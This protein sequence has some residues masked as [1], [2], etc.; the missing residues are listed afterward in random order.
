MTTS[1]N[2]PPIVIAEIAQA[3]DGS[4][5]LAHSMVD[6]V[7]DSGTKHIKFQM[8]FADQ[9]STQYDRFRKQGF[10]Q[11]SSRYD[12]WKR[13]EFTDQ[14]WFEIF[15]HCSDRDL[16]IVVSPF[17]N[18]ALDLCSSLGVKTIKVGSGETL[19]LP[20]LSYMRD[21]F[22]SFIVSTG[23]STWSETD[24]AYSVLNSGNN[25]VS[26][27]QCTS[28]YPCAL[29][30]VGINNIEL[31]KKR[32]GC[33]SG[34]SDHSGK[35]SPAL[36]A[37]AKGYTDIIELHVTYSRS[38]FGPD[39]TSSIDFGELRLLND[40]L[41]D[42]HVMLNHP[43]QKHDISQTHQTLRELFGRSLYFS[44]DLPAGTRL[45]TD[46][47]RLKKPGGFLSHDNL[48]SLLGKC[49]RRSVVYDEPLANEL[50]NDL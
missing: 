37:Y 8:H 13:I 1:F 20:F 5:G 46:H 32:Y 50:F 30:N 6:S 48:E 22:D 18:Y 10:P 4:L 29:T 17:S 11:D 31:I 9:E 33:R 49:I 14:Q 16:D 23:M 45:T 42:I 43:T 19:N 47:V 36:A 2:E 27:L 21:R 40:L 24:Q 26:I 7:A 34:L 12:Y 28:E 3:H 25:D 15:K 41:S 38:A 44:Q 39:S 35:I